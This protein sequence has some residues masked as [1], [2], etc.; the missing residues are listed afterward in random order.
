M[1]N[2]IRQ[3]LTHRTQAPRL[4]VLRFMI[5]V[6]VVVLVLVSVLGAAL[7][8]AAFAAALA[9]IATEAGVDVAWRHRH[10]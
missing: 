10:R 4:V 5:P 7:F 8:W 2:A 3:V 6:F 9:T 1:G